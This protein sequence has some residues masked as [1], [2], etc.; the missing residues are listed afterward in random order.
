MH[1]DF[2]VDGIAYRYIAQISGDYD[3][4]MTQHIEVYKGQDWIG[5]KDDGQ[6]YGYP[7]RHHP[8][9]AMEGIAMVIAREIVGEYLKPPKK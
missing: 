1:K 4:G 8:P 9:Q 6:T 7:P 3:N 5:S 2:E